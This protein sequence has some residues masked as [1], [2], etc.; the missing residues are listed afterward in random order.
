MIYTDPTAAAPALADTF[1]HAKHILLLAHINPD[2]DA[3]GS[4]LGMWHMLRSQA[5]TVT[6]LASSALPTYTHILPGIE[7]VHVY[8]RGMSLPDADLI[9]L[10]DANTLERTGPLYEDHPEELT[11]YP[12]V[13]VDHHITHVGEG[14]L[15]LIVPESASCADLV[16][17]LLV[18]LDQP[19]TPAIATCLYLGIIT[20]T[21][22]FQTNSTTT[23]TLQAAAS[24]MHAGANHHDIVQAIYYNTPF[25]TLQLMGLIFSEIQRDGELVWVT[26]SQKML[27]Q[28][29]APDS[30]LDDIINLMQRIEGVRACVVFKERQNGETKIGMRSKPDFN[31]GVIAQHLGGGGHAQAAG[32]TLHMPP[33]DALHDVLPLI[34]EKLLG[35]R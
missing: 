11:D 33:E 17:R 32:A 24:L 5:K 14:M 2:G 19:I 31:V 30:A 20:D 9:C 29:N 3:I 35:T 6:A 26:V 13:I 23:Q 27:R 28:S 18:E 12:L 1:A 4:M 16:Y 22:S 8:E 21:Q 15:N 7:H 25:Q 10:V 34:R